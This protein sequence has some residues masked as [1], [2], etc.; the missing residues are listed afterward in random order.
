MSKIPRPIDD[1]AQNALAMA[2]LNAIRNPV[3]LVNENGYVSFANWEA[4]AFGASAAHLGRQ[5]WQH[6]F[7]SA[8]RF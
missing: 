8:A 5:R 3:I 7:H 4:E 2:V 6:S 1:S